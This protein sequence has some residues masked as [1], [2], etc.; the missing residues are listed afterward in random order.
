MGEVAIDIAEYWRR[1][2]REEEERWKKLFMY[3]MLEREKMRKEGRLQ[4][5][6]DPFSYG[7]FAASGRGGVSALGFLLRIQPDGTSLAD[8]VKRIGELEDEDSPFR[9]LWEKLSEDPASEQEVQQ[10]LE[11]VIQDEPPRMLADA[12]RERERRFEFKR[13][14]REKERLPEDLE[15]VRYD[16]RV[17][18]KLSF[19]R[20]VMPK[21]LFEELTNSLQR[22]GRF[23]DNDGPK[24]EK[25]P[26]PRPAVS[27]QQYV[28]SK[29]IDPKVAIDEK[30]ARLANS[31]D[32]YTAAAYVLAA[33]EQKDAEV[34]DP[35]KA[36]AR[37]L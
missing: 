12:Q 3:Y 27:Y 34:F 2:K 37:A 26:E 23:L 13:V 5:L 7:Y 1:K 30:S 33:W 35:Q 24:A 19:L 15:A 4:E 31:G 8:R 36:D 11:R 29:S 14:H 20:L 25:E 18:D 10:A 32:V 21:E 9:R 22:E 28:E 16:R 6:D 17:E